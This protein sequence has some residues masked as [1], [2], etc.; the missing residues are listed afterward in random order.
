MPLSEAE[1]QV[2][3]SSCAHKHSLLPAGACGCLHVLPCPVPSLPIMPLNSWRYAKSCRKPVLQEGMLAALPRKSRRK[4][5]RR[6]LGEARGDGG[7]AAEPAGSGGHAWH[8]QQVPPVQL[9]SH[10]ALNASVSSLALTWGHNRHSY[11]PCL[12][13]TPR[14]SSHAAK[15]PCGTTLLKATGSRAPRQLDWQVPM[16]NAHQL[17]VQGQQ[18]AIPIARCGVFATLLLRQASG[19]VAR[20]LVL[21]LSIFQ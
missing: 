16:S 7:G 12:A 10:Q 18:A 13:V 14:C 1:V 20:C 4:V 8:G 5:Q 11:Y 21:A 15:R 17:L 9:H 6:V 19:S 3:I 2:R